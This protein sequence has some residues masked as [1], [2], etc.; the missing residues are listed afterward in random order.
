MARIPENISESQETA[1]PPNL[2]LRNSYTPEAFGSGVA[3]SLAHFSDTEFRLQQEREKDLNETS[4]LDAYSKASKAKSYLLYDPDKG[5]YARQ[6]DKVTGI[7]DDFER[8]NRSIGENASMG[9]SPEAKQ[10]FDGMWSRS[11]ISDRE[12]VMKHEFG[13]RQKYRLATGNSVI[14]LAISNAANDYAN[15]DV[16]SRSKSEILGAVVQTLPGASKETIAEKVLEGYST[17]HKG[18]V[19]RLASESPSRAE[20]YY[21]TN[22]DEFTAADHVQVS[23]F[24]RGQIFRSKVL[25]DAER[26]TKH[27]GPVR[28]LYDTFFQGNAQGQ[29]LGEA[30]TQQES[31][32]KPTVRAYNQGN[33]EKTAVGLTQVLVGTAREISAELGDGLIKSSMSP[34]EIETILENPATNLK[35]G[36]HYLGKAL[37]TFGGDL[38]AALIAYNAGPGNAKKWLAAGR[39]Y[40]VL[41]DRAQTEPYTRN[42]MA[43]YRRNLGGTYPKTAQNMDE[44]GVRPSATDAQLSSFREHFSPSSLGGTL[45][46]PVEDGAAQLFD[47]MPEVVKQGIQVTAAGGDLLVNTEDAF[48]R[49]WL[50]Y[51]AET[52]GITTVE[53]DEGVT[54]SAGRGP[55]DMG[56]MVQSEEYDLDEWLN[57]AGKIEDPARRDAVTKELM[58]RHGALQKAAKQDENSLKQEAWSLALDGKEIPVEL[59]KKLTP[60]YLSSIN[61]YVSKRDATGKIQTDWATWANLRLKTDEELRSLGDVMQYRSKL[62]DTEFKTLVDMVREV[63][64]EGDPTKKGLTGAVRTRSQIVED[65]IKGHFKKNPELAGRLNA[66]VDAEVTAFYDTYKK[67]PSAIE[68]QGMV[69]RLIL[70]ADVHSQYS[71]QY[72]FEVKPG[73]TITEP[74]VTGEADVPILSLQAARTN[75]RELFGRPLTKEEVPWA[76][77]AALAYKRGAYIRTPPELRQLLIEMGTKTDRVDAMFGRLMVDMFEVK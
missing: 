66:A 35:Y 26:I 18:V 21:N 67:Q 46:A 31:G 12:G 56:V 20:Q 71:D 75:S 25:Q 77:S 40:S 60:S 17:L 33:P 5:L 36:M 63:R 48:A 43:M 51:N 69:D 28:K 16:I 62:G 22:K 7:M 74:L 27:G 59:Q 2:Y 42:V 3:K 38:E 73:E 15:P 8:E 47:A 58:R 9:L 52:Y 6:G 1:A 57:E 13:E 4:A 30:L 41:P 68:L 45:S 11:E 55:T 72:M 70:R 61:E 19:M 64:G 39:D 32:F 54:L 44:A 14:D 24:L 10:K 37:K 53:G 76:Y 49:E 34:K 23:N 65:T 29:A 50:I